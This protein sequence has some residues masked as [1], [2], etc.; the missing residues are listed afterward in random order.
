MDNGQVNSGDWT[1]MEE[2]ANYAVK[3][4]RER[5]E[6]W[7]YG[8]PTVP[9]EK[10][11]DSWGDPPG[12]I[13]THEQNILIPGVDLG[14]V[15]IG[16]QPSL[17]MYENPEEALKAYHDKNTAPNHQYLAFYKWVEEEFD[18]VIHFGTHGTL[19]FREGKEVGMSKD[20][21]P[22]ILIG[23]MPNIYVYMVDNTSEATIA[24]RRSYAL[25]ISHA[26]PAY[27]VS[28]AYDEYAEL[29]DLLQE[30]HRARTRDPQ[31]AKIVHEDIMEKAKDLHLGGIC[32]GYIR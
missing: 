11:I 25:M 16:L 21:F 10:M 7:L 28:D 15:F 9:R 2:T 24:K 1:S 29:D 14:N 6:E 13:M 22:D 4:S 17:G 27:M 18:V 31:R 5:Y 30:Y 23:D 26:S 3:I 20:C 32:G 8:I 19:E 12:E